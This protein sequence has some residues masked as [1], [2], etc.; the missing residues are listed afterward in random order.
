VNIN[1]NV[2]LRW[3]EGGKEKSQAMKGATIE[4]F[5]LASLCLRDGRRKEGEGMRQVVGTR[6]IA[7]GME[8][9]M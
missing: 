1:A 3:S 6:E 5:F 9:N 2:E 7:G 8:K 4:R